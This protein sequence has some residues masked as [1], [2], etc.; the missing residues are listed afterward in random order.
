MKDYIKGFLGMWGLVIALS[1]TPLV[2]SVFGLSV[3]IY[4]YASCFVV[5]K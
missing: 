2:I 3:F 4:M 1:N 5:R